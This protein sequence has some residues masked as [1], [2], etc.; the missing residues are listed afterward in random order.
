[1]EYF[2]TTLEEHKVIYLDETFD[3]INN[4]WMYWGL[5]F[6]RNFWKKYKSLF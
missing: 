6:V 4:D 2:N 1:M 5:S 3:Y